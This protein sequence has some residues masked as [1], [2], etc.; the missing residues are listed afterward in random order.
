MSN[1]DNI[2]VE[3]LNAMRAELAEIKSETTDIKQR[4]H[5][6]DTSIIDLRRNDVH[7]YEDSAR[8][9]VTMDRLLERV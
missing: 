3:H 7:M 8:Q 5:S 2:I 1:I 9:Q 6:I 4:L